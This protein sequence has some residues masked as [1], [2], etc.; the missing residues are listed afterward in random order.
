MPQTKK[1][2]A[3][4]R[5]WVKALESGQYRQGTGFLVSRGRKFDKFCCLGVLCDMAV[6]AKVIAAPKSYS[7]TPY[8]Y[9]GENKVLPPTV[10]RWAGLKSENGDFGDDGNTLAEL[11][12]DGN[13]FKQIAK[14][15]R[16][17]PDGIFVP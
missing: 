2:K 11:N 16:S 12:D 8:A 14:I 17:N 1:Q 10:L 5:R 7:N 15:I 6:R 9:C 13:T 3:V 4:V